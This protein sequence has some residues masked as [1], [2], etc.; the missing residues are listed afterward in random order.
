MPLAAYSGGVVR[1]VAGDFTSS[2]TDDP[3]AP[4]AWLPASGTYLLALFTCLSLP[5]HRN[6]PGMVRF[7]EQRGR[8]A[9]FSLLSYDP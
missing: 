4:A 5:A 2:P 3:G 9:Y 1:S 6:A 7:C 8:T